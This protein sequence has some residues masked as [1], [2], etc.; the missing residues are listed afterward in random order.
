MKMTKKHFI[1]LAD[2]LKRAG[3]GPEHESITPILRFLR[4]QNPRFME[5]RWLAY[6]AGECG[7]NGGKIK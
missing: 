7:K 2:E 5:P 1:A 3:I 4:S 6:L